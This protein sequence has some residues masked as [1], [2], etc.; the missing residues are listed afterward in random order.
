MRE[1][2]ANKCVDKP[3]KS[4]QTE[5]EDQG[6]VNTLLQC[7]TPAKH[8]LTNMKEQAQVDGGI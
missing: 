4:I 1:L 7:I 6:T 5:D 2:E 3:Y 8:T